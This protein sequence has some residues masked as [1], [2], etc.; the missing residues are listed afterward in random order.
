MSIA[1]VE[2]EIKRAMTAVDAKLYFGP[3]SQHAIGH[4]NTNDYLAVENPNGMWAACPADFL[5][6]RSKYSVFFDEFHAGAAA[7]ENQTTERTWVEVDDGATGT[8]AFSDLTI[9]GVLNVLSSGADNDYHLMRSPHKSADPG[10][11]QWYESR[12]KLAE[13]NTN[14]ANWIVGI[15]DVTTTGLL[16]DNGAGTLAA[17][18]DGCCF[19]KVDGEALI[20]FETSLATTRSTDQSWAF[21]DNTWHTVGFYS[22]TV[23]LTTPYVDGVAGTT[24]IWPATGGH[25][26][27]VFGVKAGSGNAETLQMDYILNVHKR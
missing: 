6:Q 1:N 15:S 13:A 20:H 16:E 24:V 12:F 25:S 5:H 2:N 17:G 8:N 4:N 18:Y 22:D 14:A 10:H 7:S 23:G 26:Y 11:V 27:H 3:D 19:Y 21:S 9:Y